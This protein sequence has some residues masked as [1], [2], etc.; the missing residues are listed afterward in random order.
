[1]VQSLFD[2]LGD[3]FVDPDSKREIIRSYLPGL[4]DEGFSA[5]ASL[6]LFKDVGL[7]IGRSDFLSIYREVLGLEN[8]QNR[9]RYV[10]GDAIPSEGILGIYETP[11]DNDYRF[12]YRYTALDQQTGE[13]YQSYVGL[14]RNSL[15]TINN[16]EA[17]AAEEIRKLYPAIA[18]LLLSVETWKG[19]KA[20]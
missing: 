14:N 15:D 7:G 17:E 10:R 5:N 11:I 3:D 16:M 13:E 2:D 18:S 19:F 4:I 6:Q 9:V 20:G 8:Q 1:M 12:I